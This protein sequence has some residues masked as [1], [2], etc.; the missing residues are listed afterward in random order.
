[1]TTTGLPFDD[2]KAHPQ[3]DAVLGEV[4]AR[5][6]HP[7]TAPRRLLHFAFMTDATSARA[8]RQ[9]LTVFCERQGLP[10]PGDHAKHHR[11]TLGDM[12][13]RWEQHSE[14]TTYTVDVPGDPAR[15]FFPDPR[16]L[17]TPFT[18]L[19]A[20][21]PLL[22][23]VDLHLLPA[24]AQV[25]LEA[26][27]DPMSLAAAQV[28]N[29]DAIAA[30]DFRAVRDG[31]VRIAVLDTKLDGKAAGALVI[32]LL[33]IETYRILALYGLPLAQRLS[34]SVGAAE[35]ELARISNA[36]T[37]TEGL[38]TDN[39]LLEQLTGL[40]ARTEAEATEAAFR[41]GASRAYDG[42]VQQRLQAI[43]EEP[44]LAYPTI[45]S[46]LSRRMA[47]AMRTCQMLQ[48]RQAD[49]SRKLTRAANLLRTR[50]DVEIERQNRDLLHSMND[51][52][53]MQLRLQ[54]TVEGLSVAAISYYVV[55]LGSYVFK[56]LKDLGWLP[57]DPG[58]A[59]ALF[60]PVSI[61]G[62][63]VVVRQ[64]RRRFEKS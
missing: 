61:L 30:T 2:I 23:A 58:I 17:P 29:G 31:F 1:M 45:S 57:V 14:F 33:E 39:R 3:R 18:G 11:M 27:F 5:P 28:V 62:I 52:A 34:P 43:K 36:M 53:R 9:A 46:F 24:A 15:P 10:G 54:Q 26:V 13:L 16:A 50:V 55:S 59:T 12:S 47:P 32:R 60:V 22:V 6:F 35:Q 4:H 44:Y 42:I 48:E 63:A 37:S 64:I 25:D 41:F 21:G 56:A 49:L 40:A 8:D 20:P 38:E 7:L 51:R 19:P